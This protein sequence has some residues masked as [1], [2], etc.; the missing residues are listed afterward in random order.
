MA[1]NVRAYETLHGVD[2][3]LQTRP[4]PEQAML[5][6]AQQL[7]GNLVR[8]CQH[9]GSGP[10][11]LVLTLGLKAAAFIRGDTFKAAQATDARGALFYRPPT[12][13]KF[14]TCTF[15]VIHLVHPGCL[16]NPRASSR[17]QAHEAWCRGE[18]AKFVRAALSIV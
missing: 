9:L 13:R 3:G 16:M 1:E 6:M 4:H 8:L 2:L 15:D 7:P 10:A 12:L 5:D 14:G 17:R 11:S 18:G